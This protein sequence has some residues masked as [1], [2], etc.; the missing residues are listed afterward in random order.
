MTLKLHHRILQRGYLTFSRFSRGMTLGVRAMLLGDGGVTLVMHSYVPGWYL[1][2]GGVEAGETFA[3]ALAREID[4]EAGARLTGP[5]LLFGLYRNAQ[6]DK[7]DHVALFVC[8]EWARVPGR[9]IP[10]R[11]IV[12]MDHFPLDALPDG[13]T[14]GTLARIQEV[15]RGDIPSA[16]W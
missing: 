4:E 15:A 14:A 8:R 10:N 6:A 11:E 9:K 12:A 5:A 3:E 2:G 7:R 1:P 13:T 16:D